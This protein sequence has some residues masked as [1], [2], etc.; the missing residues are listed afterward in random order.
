MSVEE[1]IAR[2]RLQ[3]QLTA[4]AKDKE[5]RTCGSRILVAWKDGTYKLRCKDGFTP[6]IWKPAHY[7][8]RRLIEMTQPSRLP[9]TQETMLA[10][11]NES[12]SLGLFPDKA[13]TPDQLALLAKVALAYQ[14]DPW[15]GE[16]IPYQGKPYVTIAGRRRK[17]ADAGHHT[18]FSFRSLT[19]EEER[20]Y[21]KLGA[22]AEGDVAGYC[23]ATDVDTGAT[24]EGFGRVLASEDAGISGNARNFVPVVMRKIEMAQKRQERR[25]REILYGPVARPAG[26]DNI[27]VFEEGDIVE[28]TARVIEDQPRPGSPAAKADTAALDQGELGKCPEHDIE[29]TVGESQ[30]GV[31]FA[32]HWDAETNGYC[33]FARVLGARFGDAY[34]ARYGEY[35]KTEADAWLKEHYDGRTWSKMEP[36]QQLAAVNLLVDGVIAAQQEASQ[37]EAEELPE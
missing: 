14:L 18:S 3:E 31:A 1:Q 36:K 23:I 24:V 9:A 17:D 34:K 20:C 8:K 11:I 26:L 4:Y 32:S 19:D 27:E 35:K 13:T 5:C 22:L 15:M 30:W 16:I 28:G 2:D 37:D 21:K 29:W 6:E 33:R 25:A 12:Q 10:H 7:S